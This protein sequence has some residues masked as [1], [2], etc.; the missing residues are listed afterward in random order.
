MT[1]YERIKLVR[2]KN[3]LTMDKFG[4]VIGLTGGTVSRIESGL[5]AVT[6]QTRISVCR[7]FNVREEWLRTGAGE[8]LVQRSREDEI[9]E[10]CKDITAGNP[11]FRRRFISALA[12]LNPEQWLMLEELTSV[13]IAEV[14]G[15][16]SE[17]HEDMGS[18]S[19][20]DLRRRYEQEARAEADEYYQEILQE[21]LA[22]DNARV[23]SQ[24]S[25]GG[26]LA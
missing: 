24:N 4:K 6:D 14:Q 15:T 21:K 25:G 20:D 8:M 9:T 13:L 16:Q 22:A 1:E 3:G 2:K 11:D 18:E 17:K 10:F 7:E 5:S 19:E 23:F 12:K 26:M